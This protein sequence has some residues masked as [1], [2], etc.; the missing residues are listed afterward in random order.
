MLSNNIIILANNER[1]ALPVHKLY[2]YRVSNIYTVLREDLS[3]ESSDSFSNNA[4]T[5]YHLK[6]IYLCACVC[7][8]VH[9]LINIHLN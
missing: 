3:F 5:L 6:I 8:C 1:R 4:T 7:V 9:S 2:V